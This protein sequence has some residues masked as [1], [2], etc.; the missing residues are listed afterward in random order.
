MITQKLKSL[1]QAMILSEG[2]HADTSSTS[3]GGGP[4]VSYRNHNPGNLRSSVFALGVRD[5]FAFFIDDDTGFFAM[6]WDVWCKCTNR[7]S[8]DLKPESSLYDLLRVYCCAT[9]EELENYV[10]G[11]EEKTGLL[12]TWKLEDIVS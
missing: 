5:K 11:I 1:C 4:S 2:W 8:T 3:K 6:V 7:T 10:K 12:R 9:G